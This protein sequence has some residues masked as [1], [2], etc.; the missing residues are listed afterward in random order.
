MSKTLG[1]LMPSLHLQREQIKRDAIEVATA[2]RER[3]KE[4]KA[5]K[6]AGQLSYNEY[7]EDAKRKIKDIEGQLNKCAQSPN[8]LALGI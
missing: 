3:I 7:M 2:M 8:Q 5:E 1:E 6:K 4:I